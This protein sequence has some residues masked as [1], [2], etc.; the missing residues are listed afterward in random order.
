MNTLPALKILLLLGLTGLILG[1]LPALAEVSVEIDESRGE[2][3]GYHL[4][5]NNS[6]K[7]VKIWTF[8]REGKKGIHPLNTGGDAI[9]DGYPLLLENESGDGLPWVVWDRDLGASRQLVWSRWTAT[10]WTEVRALDQR[11]AGDQTDPHLVFNGTGRPYLAYVQ[12]D[13]GSG[14]VRFTIF[15][16]S[17]WA[18]S[19]P[20][21]SDGQ[22]ASNPSIEIIDDSTV[23]ITYDLPDGSSATRTVHFQDPATITDDVYPFLINTASV[24]E[25]FLY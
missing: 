12:P 13:S 4:K 22:D 2:Y 9:G 6:S 11:G 15:L 1:S 19:I 23:E 16:R 17:V 3:L 25:G 5:A 10:G 8:N 21:S 18:L 24:T 14:V 7:V 20:V